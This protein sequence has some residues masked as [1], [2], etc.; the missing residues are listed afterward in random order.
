MIEAGRAWL[1][2]PEPE[3]FHG[4]NHDI[5]FYFETSCL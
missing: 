2:S 3:N 4:I 1:V 5:L